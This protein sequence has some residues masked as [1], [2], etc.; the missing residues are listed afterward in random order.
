LYSALS[1]ELQVLFKN[2]LT[3]FGVVFL[4][5]LFNFEQLYIFVLSLTKMESL[6]VMAHILYVFEQMLID[7]V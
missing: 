1:P 7:T 3:L 6:M 4:H 2:V 5:V